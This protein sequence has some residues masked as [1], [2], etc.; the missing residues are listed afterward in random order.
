MRSKYSRV[1]FCSVLQCGQIV[2]MSRC[3]ITA[4]TEEAT[5]KGS[6]PMSINRVN[7]LGASL[8]CSVENTKCPVSEA[9]IAISA[10]SMS[11]ISPTMITFGSCRKIWRNPIANVNPMSDRTAIWLIPFSSYSTGSSM[12]MIRLVTELMELRNAYSEVDLPEP[13]GP[14]TRKMP[15]GLMMMSRMASSSFLE[16]PS[17]SRLRKIFPRVNNRSETLSP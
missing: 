14:V 5:R 6:M 3:A 4:S 16:N 11:R 1:T 13:V 7:A 15:C 2:R 9:R 12:V 17:L 10:V 8:V